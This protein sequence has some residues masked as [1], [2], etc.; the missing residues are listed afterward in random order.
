MTYRLKSALA[1]LP[2]A[3]FVAYGRSKQ[4]WSSRPIF[5]VLLLLRGDRLEEGE[6]GEKTG[7]QDPWR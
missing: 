4:E 1:A 6:G 3:F 5:T 7:M 2:A